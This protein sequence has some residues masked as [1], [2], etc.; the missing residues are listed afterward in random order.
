[1]M[2]FVRFRGTSC[3]SKVVPGGSPRFMTERC[4]I[5][6]ARKHSNHTWIC[7][8]PFRNDYYF[9]RHSSIFTLSKIALMKKLPEVLELDLSPKQE[10]ISAEMEA[11]WSVL[12]TSHQSGYE[13]AVQNNGDSRSPGF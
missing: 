11:T 12:N 1:M 8:C 9:M 13:F 2:T 6:E 5:F 7:D 3:N 4:D 10:C